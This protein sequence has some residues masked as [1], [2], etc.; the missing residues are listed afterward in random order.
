MFGI[1]PH[2]VVMAGHSRSKNGVLSHAYGPAISLGDALCLPKRDHRDK[3]GDDKEMQ[4]WWRRRN[5]TA[6]Q[7]A[8]MP[9]ISI[10]GVLGVKPA[11]REAF[12]TVS[13]MAAE[14]DSPTAPQ[15]SQIMNTTGSPLS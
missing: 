12:F 14:A 11:A 13:A 7:C 3:P 9:L 15:R 2:Q 6:R 8:Q 4:T 1:T 10:T 5:Y